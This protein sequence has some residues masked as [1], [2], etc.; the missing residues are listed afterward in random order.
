[1]P[2]LNQAIHALNTLKQDDIVVV[3]SML[4]PPVHVKK[5]MEAICILC[6]KPPIKMPSKDNPRVRVDDYWEASKKFLG[7]W[8]SFLNELK[9]F[10]KD[11]IPEQV[12][13]KIRKQSTSQTDFNP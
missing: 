11:N 3:R 13:E 2:K 4:N 6:Q 8:K 9:T 7:D 12:I 1:M 5:V 10:D